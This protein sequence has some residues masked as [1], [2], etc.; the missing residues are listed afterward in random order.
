M[1]GRS[2]QETDPA[3]PAS[4]VHN[5][6]GP[7]AQGERGPLLLRALHAWITALNISAPHCKTGLRR[8]ALR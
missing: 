2:V 7:G 5:G 6:D 4:K 3:F 1:F 8:P